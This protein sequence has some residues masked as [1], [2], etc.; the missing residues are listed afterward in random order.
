MSLLPTVKSKPKTEWENFTTLIYGAPKTGKST[1]ASQFDHPIFLATEAGL[2]SL[3]TFN[4]AIDSW[5]KFLEVCGEIAQ[6]KHEFKTVV[7]DTVDN[8]FSMCSAYI[9]KKNNIQHESE[10][11]WGKG[12][13][14]VKEEFAR[15]ITKLSLLPYGLLLISHAEPEEI[16][17]RTGTIT[18][19]RPT[20]PRQ[21][22]EKVL[23]MCDFI[24]FCTIETGSEGERRFVCTKPSE[25]WDG[26]DRTGKLPSKIN[27]SY[28]DIKKEFDKAIKG[29]K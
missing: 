18:K 5:D 13:K 26:G 29:G 1:L 27:M 23:P 17:T 8:L 28:A 20:M 14:L 25:N 11:D 2:N 6:G 19:W 15:A 24:F 3:E 9:C 12:W 10:L 7:V 16:K 4:V 21:A 22:K